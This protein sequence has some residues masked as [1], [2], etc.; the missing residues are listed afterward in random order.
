MDDCNTQHRTIAIAGFS[1]R[2]A[3]QCAKRQGFEVVAIDMC[4]D[5]DLLSECIVHLR[6]DDPNW[7]SVLNSLYPSAPLLLAGGMEQRIELLAQCHLATKRPGPNGS[8]LAAM[9]NSRNWEDWAN[10]SEIGWPLTIHR[11]QDVVQILNQSPNGPWLLKSLQS[12]GGIGI[13]ELVDKLEQRATDHMKQMNAYIQKRLQGETVG[14]TFLSSEFG[15]A[16]VGAAAALPAPARTAR[17]FVYR[18]SLG[19]IRL[20]SQLVDKLQRFANVASKESQILGLWQA[21]FLLD[22]NELTLLE[23]NPRW[24]ASMDLLDA[25]LNLHLVEM[26]VASVCKLLSPRSFERFNRYCLDQFDKQHNSMLGKLIVYAGVPMTITNAQSDTWWAHRWE[27]STH[28]ADNQVQYADI[29]TAGTSISQGDPL[30][31]VL[32]TGN[33]AKAVL[34]V[35]EAVNACSVANQISDCE[36]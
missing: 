4:A 5:R 20:P 22:K 3:A 26:H 15:C 24:S 36:P 6:L 18:G 7:P 31:S 12:A 35:L 28:G 27:R 17:K 32:T 33:S 16:V 8:Q 23:I 30:L 2:A 25:Q 21:D 19:P 9:R 1:V 14:I 29:P 11:L 13:S 10:S 34:D